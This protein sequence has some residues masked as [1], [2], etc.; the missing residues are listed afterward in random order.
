MSAQFRQSLLGYFWLFFPPLLN[1]AV[2]IFLNSRQIIKIA[3]TGVPYPVFVLTGN[4][5]WQCLI[6]LL[7][8]PIQ[9]VHRERG[10]LTK[11]N[12]SREALLVSSFLEGGAMAF[13]PLAAVPLILIVFH[14][15]FS[16]TML[17]APIGILGLCFFAFAIG[18][19]LTPIG[20]LYQDVG[21]AIPVIARF[22][23][24]V[25][26]VIYALP[27]PGKTRTLL[28][29]NPATPL[30]ET[31]RDWMLGRPADL[32]SLFGLYFGISVIA[33]FIG[34]LV[35]RLAMPIIVERMSA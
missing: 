33:L 27:A 29:L 3:D 28:M 2:F 4:L 26:P 16:L 15:P 34:V 8:A 32:A 10:L 22:W 25:T 12:F 31:A 19:I 7:Q 18:V 17:L 1:S 6:M 20:T 9:S 35:Y 14:I 5:L 24:F 30:L 23:M 11:L 21:R 13:I